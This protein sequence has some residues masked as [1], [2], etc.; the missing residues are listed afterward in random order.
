MAK[1]SPVPFLLG[2]INGGLP[3]P[4]H[5]TTELSR[6]REWLSYFRNAYKLMPY[7]RSTYACSTGILAAF[8]HTITD[9]PAAEI[10]DYQLSQS[11]DPDL[12]TCQ[13]DPIGGR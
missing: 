4:K 8:E 12:F 9:L 2:P 13:S 6:E 5:F 11:V 1:W 10:E 3:W 7:Y